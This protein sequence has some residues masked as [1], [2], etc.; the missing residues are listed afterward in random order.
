MKLQSGVVRGIGFSFLLTVVFY[1]V[2]QK[3]YQL[4]FSYGDDHRVLAMLHPDKV[5]NSY[6]EALYGTTPDLKGAWL[7]DMHVGRFKPLGWAYEDLLGMMFGDNAHLFRLSKLVIFFLS[8]F[9]LFGICIAL[10]VDWFSGMLVLI[11]YAFGRNNE[12]WWT[13]IPPPQDLGEMFMLGGMYIWLLYRKKGVTGYYLLPALFFLLA[14]LTKESFN[15]CIPLLLLTE[16]LFF[17]P[18]KRVFTKEYLFS[19]LSSAAVF[20]CLVATIL[21]VKKVYAYPYPVSTISIIGYNAIQFIGASAFM[22]APII[23]LIIGRKVIERRTL[24][25]VVFIFAIWTI[26]Q[27]VLLKGIKLDDQHHYLIPWLIYPLIL[28]ALA[29]SEIRKVS[30]KWFSGLVVV[31]GLAAL[32]FMRNTYSTS[33]SYSAC[34]Q[35]YYN[36]IDAIKN[37]PNVP[38]VVYLSEDPLEKDWLEGTRVIMDNAGIKKELYFATTVASI[39]DWEKDYAAHTRQNAYKHMSLDSVFNP[40][41]KWIVLVEDPAKNGF[42]NDNLSFYKRKDSSFVKINGREKYISGSYFYFSV[43]YPGRSIGDL[44][45]GNFNAE[46]NKGFYAVKMN[47]LK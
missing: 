16:Y 37:D 15:F 35:G 43:S 26:E 19:L 29:L 17:N 28:T 25:K 2:T 39:P 11:F 40:D 13:L 33:Q 38:K 47:S 12:C 20:L 10:G 31:Y 41:G 46:N 9:F 18:A 5:S 3:V 14:G 22:L 44:L 36:M 32:I 4:P 30:A 27:L 45:K 23:L 24:N 21:H 42:M 8:V 6:K 7:N 1:L 34:L